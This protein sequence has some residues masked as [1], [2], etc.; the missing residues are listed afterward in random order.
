[1]EEGRGTPILDDPLHNQVCGEVTATVNL[2]EDTS[3]FGLL[4]ASMGREVGDEKSL[5]HKDTR[6]PSTH[7]RP[8]PARMIAPTSQRQPRP[9]Q[10]TW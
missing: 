7:G 5:D 3:S 4:K 2:T 1:M 8:I 9:G 10:P 6:C